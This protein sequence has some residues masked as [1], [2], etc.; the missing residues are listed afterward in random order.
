MPERTPVPEAFRADANEPSMTDPQRTYLLGLLDEREIDADAE[1]Q[2]RARIE[3]GDV[4]KSRASNWIGRLKEKPKRAAPITTGWHPVMVQEVGQGDEEPSEFGIMA[5]GKKTH[6]DPYGEEVVPSGRYAIETKDLPWN[7][8]M[9]ND[10]N[11]YRVYVFRPDEKPDEV[12]WIVKQQVSD[13]MIKVPRARQFDVLTA[14]A[15]DPAEASARYGA[16]FKRC[17]VCGR[18]LTN[19]ESRERGIGPICAARWGW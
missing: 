14:I 10:T 11:F 1:A 2:M 16:E 17:G 13:D 3:A 4:T 12:W 9:V 18:G 15:K 19:D 7:V 6:T 8:G 5:R